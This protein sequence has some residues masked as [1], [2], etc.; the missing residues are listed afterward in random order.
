MN[1]I[2]KKG[3]RGWEET[4]IRLPR[5][6]RL[7]NEGAFEQSRGAPFNETKSP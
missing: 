5:V 3:E 2:S 7:H 1:L 4:A 6:S